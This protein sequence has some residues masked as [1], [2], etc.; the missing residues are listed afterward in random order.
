[1]ETNINSEYDVFLKVK[2]FQELDSKLKEIIK[3][4]QE[5]ITENGIIKIQLDKLTT[6][7]KELLDQKKDHL[8][9]L[10]KESK[11]LLQNERTDGKK[12]YRFI[13]VYFFK[14]KE[15]IDPIERRLKHI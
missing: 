3:L 8:K 6:K 10:K 9:K 11:E 12:P 13:H 1:M 14:K 4:N 5:L 15:K 2:G 7:Y